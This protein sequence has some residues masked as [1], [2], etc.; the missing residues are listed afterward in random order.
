VSLPQI[1]QSSADGAKPSCQRIPAVSV[2]A[3]RIGMRAKEAR[4]PESET[5]GLDIQFSVFGQ[6]KDCLVT[7]PEAKPRN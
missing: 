6:R 4:Y 5:P 7:T 2:F 1:W 3:V